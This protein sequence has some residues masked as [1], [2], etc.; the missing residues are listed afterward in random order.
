MK[1]IKKKKNIL[2]FAVR[3]FRV[4]CGQLNFF[5]FR[6]SFKKIINNIRD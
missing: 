5:L 3:E 1:V 6:K 2:N 4:R